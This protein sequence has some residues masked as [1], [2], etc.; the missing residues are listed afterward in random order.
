MKKKIVLLLVLVTV[1]ILVFCA[2]TQNENIAKTGKDDTFNYS[3]LSELQKN[4]TLN[5]AD[6]KSVDSVFSITEDSNLAIN[7]SSA[8][9]AQATQRVDLQANSYYLIEY[10]YTANTFSSYGNSSKGFD[11]LYISFLEDDD[12]N[13]G[14]NQVHHRGITSTKTTARLYFKTKG[15]KKTTVA[16]NVGNPEYQVSVNSVTIYDFKLVKV[17]KAMIESEN[18]NCFTFSTDHY[19][20]ASNKNIVWVTLGAV[21]IA[22][23]GYA[24]YV[25]FQ[26]NMAIKGEYKNKFLLKL[27]DG[28]WMGILLV[29]GVTLFIR[30]LIDIL[31]TCLAGAKSYMTMGY[32]VEGYASQALFIANYGT[33]F[34]SESLGKFC[35]ANEYTY[36]AVGSN[37]ILLYLLG[38]IGLLGRIFD[39]SNPYLATIFFIK[40]FASVADVATAI[41]IYVMVKKSTD[42]VGATVIGLLFGLLPVTFGM[43]SLWGFTESITVFLI[44]LTVYFILKNNYYGVA[45]TYFMAFLFSWTALIFAPI[46]IFYTIQQ[47]INSKKVLVS[48]ICGVV[49]GFVLFYLLNLPF[50]INQIKAGSAFACVVKYWNMVAKN[51]VYTANAFNFQAILGNNFGAVSTESLVVSIIFVAFMLALVAFGYFKFKNRMNL[52]LLSTAFINMVFMF[53]NNMTPVVMG[54]SLALMLIYAIMNKEKRVYFAFIAYAV[55]MFVNMSIG[56]LLY[57]YTTEVTYAIAYSTATIYVFSAFYLAITLYYL[58]ITYD[59]VA[60]KKM[61]KIQPMTLTYGGWWKNLFLR[62]RKAYYKLR[63]KTAKQN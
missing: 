6:G 7:T 29:G 5:T 45:I 37:P 43:S 9:W 60:S 62:I 10:S 39:A 42:N 26:R 12:F 25:M 16:I 63:V 23:L 19:G 51:L 38:V 24:F 55:L 13:T 56:E 54:M 58:Y 14:D 47:A 52:V 61:R 11:G 44:A 27:H 40:F 21:A 31:T 30:L 8:G 59:I 57:E 50:D 1:C 22:L 53:A 17:S 4:W 41:L 49:I 34:L 48:A 2:C 36:M 20:E 32:N 3:S 46:V 35:A 33:V 15:A 28:K 18:A